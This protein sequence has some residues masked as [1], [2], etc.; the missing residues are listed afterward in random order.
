LAHT[1]RALASGGELF[2]IGH[3]LRNLMEGVGGLQGPLVLW[4]PDEIPDELRA[5]GLRV[6]RCEESSARWLRRP[7]RSRRSTS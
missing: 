5:A 2:M 1:A 4:D 6:E 7:G 3:A